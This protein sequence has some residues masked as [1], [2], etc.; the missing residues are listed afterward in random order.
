MEVERPLEP[1]LEV[2]HLTVGYGDTPVLQQVSLALRTNQ[3]AAV[4]GPNGAGKSTLLKTI[5]GLNRPKEG[6]VLFDGEPVQGLPVWEL[7][8]RGIVYVPEGMS[9]FPDMNVLENL[10]IGAYLNRPLIAQRLDLVYELFPE[11]RERLSQRASTLS[12]G[13][14]R[15][16]TLGRGLMA[17]ARLLLLDDPFLGLSPIIVR[18]FCEAFRTIRQSG[19]TLFIAGQHVRRILNVADLAFLIE[20]GSITLSGAGDEIYGD[21]HLQRILFGS[22]VRPDGD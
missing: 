7:V 18:R 3:I 17:G 12:G 4:V 11:L 19:V 14:K 21:A 22:E 6:E 5:A 15:M 20:D 13:Q 1:L 16:I 9:V 10:E 2:R 8:R